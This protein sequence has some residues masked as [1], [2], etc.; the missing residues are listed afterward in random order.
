MIK[1]LVFT[2]AL[3]VPCLAYAA[4]TSA[5]LSVQVVDPSNG[6]VCDIG[7]PASAI[8]AAAQAAGFTHC[9]ANYDFTF[10]GN[11]TSAANTS[12]TPTRNTYN[13]ATQSTWLAGCGAS[14]T[15]ALWFNLWGYY[16]HA[17]PCSDFTIES[18][19][20]AGGKNVLHIVW[21][22]ADAA[23][24]NEMSW[25]S[26]VDNQNVPTAGTDFPNGVYVEILWRI[27]Q[28]T[29]NALNDSQPQVGFF[30]MSETGA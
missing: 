28:S 25:I 21:T 23:A 30:C 16:P 14:S 17:T 19:S 20:V 5:P 15:V 9:A 6:I 4:N 26:T 13:W 1:I 24:G 3:L 7:P 27:N 8:P 11:F 2:A 22:P 18:D 29:Q 10:V 12:F